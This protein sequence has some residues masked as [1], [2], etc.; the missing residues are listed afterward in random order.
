MAGD[1]S[2]FHD[3]FRL[4][5]DGIF[6]A[7][8][9]GRYLEVNEAAA[10]LTGYSCAEL[11]TMT[12]PDI[13]PPQTK[14]ES[15]PLFSELLETGRS[16][17]EVQGQRKDGSQYWMTVDSVKLADDRFIAFCRD[18]TS[19]H[20]AEE[21]LR[22]VEE[23][24]S[25][26]MTHTQG[27][28]FVVD[29]EGLFTLSEG[30]GLAALGLKP[31]QVVGQSALELY[32]EVPEILQ[33]I[34]EALTG[35]TVRYTAKAGEIYYDTFYSPIRDESGEVVGT[36]GMALDV[37]EQVQAE[38]DARRLAEQMERS[39]RLESLGVLAGGVAHDFN[40]L[41]MS[42]LGSA[43]LVARQTEVGSEARKGTDRIVAASEQAATLCQQLLAYAGRAHVESRPF[44]LSSC[45][46]EMVPLL[47][48]AASRKVKVEWHLENNLPF[49]DGDPAQLRQVAMNMVTN[50]SE[51]IGDRAGTIRVSTFLKTYSGT[52]LLSFDLVGTR[53][54]GRY[55]C[56]EV[57]DTG[58]GMTEE[59][60][61]RIFDPF[62]TTKVS[63]RGLGMASARG[64]IHGHEGGIRIEST[65]G[66]GSTITALFPARTDRLS[67]PEAPPAQPR[68][69]AEGALLI[70]DDEKMV[71]KTARLLLEAEGFE[72]VEAQD[73]VEAMERLAN[74]SGEF[75]GVLLDL[76]MPRMG[77]T[78]CRNEIRAR[79]PRLPIV[80]SSGFSE[81]AVRELLK[82]DP[83]SNFVQ[84]PYRIETLLT[85]LDAVFLKDPES[86]E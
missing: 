6:I 64:I 55:V 57:Q 25:I 13:L 9:Q 3:Y 74:R 34:K 38:E 41:L 80:L 32:A 33:G 59:T 36:I 79:Y 18:T 72:V 43:E 54:P 75:R 19:R 71:R 10:Q 8:G 30:K 83:H 21:A 5:P 53:A 16:T 46:L 11:V 50:A 66:Q 51:A 23:R 78:E 31:G 63:G 7:D 65:L 44:D 62:F 69:A 84:K 81:E 58:A 76:T 68:E 42:I 48:V 52:D 45:V 70:V 2:R 15:S 82:D 27:V 29:R 67:S 47:D 24:F 39:Q 61:T 37:T 86:A 56:L 17:G 26:L 28:I 85:A 12:I 60:R 77:G 35:K 20:K 1:Q 73:G 40:N 49:I 22:A 14:R 4:A